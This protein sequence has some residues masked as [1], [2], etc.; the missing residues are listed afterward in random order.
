MG[1]KGIVLATACIMILIV[2]FFEFFIFST[3]VYV[4]S[5]K[6]AS[7]TKN[8]GWSSTAH[9]F[10]FK[11]EVTDNGTVG[12]N[13][14]TVVIRLYHDWMNIS[15]PIAEYT[16][17]VQDYYSNGS[18]SANILHFGTIP[19]GGNETQTIEFAVDDS[20]YVRAVP[21]NYAVATLFLGDKI[22]DKQTLQFNQS[23]EQTWV[24]L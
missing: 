3:Q 1:K 24:F 23:L 5:A 19:A 20:Y 10:S 8:E 12:V 21:V 17:E 6:I 15:W 4:P 13:G 16:N 2:V 9:L 7:V 14:T 18:M 11:V 22:L